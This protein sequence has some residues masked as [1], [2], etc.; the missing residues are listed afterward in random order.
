MALAAFRGQALKTRISILA[1]AIFFVSIWTLSLYVSRALG[2]D[3]QRLLGVQQLST[4]RLVAA[5][6][7]QALVERMQGL[8]GVADRIAPELLRDPLALQHFLEQQPV[9]QH[10]FSG[11]LYATGMDGTATASVPASLGRKGVNFRERP[12]LIAALDQGQT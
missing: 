7:N 10:L 5:E 3:L 9:L 4:A 11:G 6:V 2:Q 1:V 8:E 12:H